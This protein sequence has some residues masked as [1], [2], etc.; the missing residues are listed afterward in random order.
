MLPPTTG[1]RRRPHTSLVQRTWGSPM[2]HFKKEQMSSPFNNLPPSPLTF[3]SLNASNHLSAMFGRLSAPG[4]LPFE[5]K[6]FGSILRNNKGCEWGGQPRETSLPAEKLKRSSPNATK[7]LSPPRTD[8]SH[9]Y[10]SPCNLII[11]AQSG[12]PC[13]STSINILTRCQSSPAN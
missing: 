1:N 7:V 8:F 2:P 5:T 3:R 6:M 9:C 10:V 11:K 13:L 4:V 12:P